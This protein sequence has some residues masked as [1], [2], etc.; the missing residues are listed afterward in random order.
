[1]AKDLHEEKL[2]SGKALLLLRNALSL[3]TD[4]LLLAGF[5]PSLPEEEALE[6]G[7]GVGTVSVLCALRGKLLH[8]DAVEIQSE[9]CSLAKENLIR[10]GL[11][12]HI[13]LIEA[14]VRAFS[15]QKSYP[16]IF[17]NPP[18]YKVGGG[19]EPKSRLSYLS[20]FEEN[21]TLSQ[22]LETVARLL[23]ANGRFF[24]V[25]PYRRKQ[26]LLEEA[27]KQ[28]LFPRRLLPVTKHEGA[29]PSLFL[30]E[31]ERKKTA[32]YE[33]SPLTLYTDKTH[34]AESATMLRLYEEGILFP[35][36]EN[37]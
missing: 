10:N 16:L 3:S 24:C 6:I 19:K 8:I 32:F 13:A 22:L 11:T 9:L 1:M 35:I 25:Y 12:D 30:I 17:S 15:P 2:G 26:E 34:T 33:E 28:A 31:L 27:R 18:Y 36:K 37:L 21:L 14:D 29:V 4:A 5:L 20:R 23:S 7:A